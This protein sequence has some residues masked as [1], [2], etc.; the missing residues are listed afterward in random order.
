[1]DK[2]HIFVSVP[3]IGAVTVLTLY[4][5]TRVASEPTDLGQE[6]EAVVEVAKGPHGGRL[7]VDG[8]FSVEVTI[9]ERGVPPMFRVYFLQEGE[10]LDAAQVALKIE[11]QRL[12]GRVDVFEFEKEADYLRGNGVVE[13]PHSF[14]VTVVAERGGR[15]HRW[16][17]P[18]YEGR[19]SFTPEAIESS[20]LVLETTGPATLERTLTIYGRIV[21]NTD[22]QADVIPRYSGVVMATHKALGD[23]VIAGELV[24][25]VQ[26]NESLQSYDVRSP[27]AGTIVH[28]DIRLGEFLPEGRIIYRVTDTST[29]WADMHVY[30]QDFPHLRLN[31]PVAIRGG[32]ELPEVTGT[33]D[34]LSPIGTAATQTML[35]R[36]EL[37]NPDG[38]WR[39]GWF[40]T[41]EVLVERVEVPVAVRASALQTF[42][43]WDVVFVNEGSLFEVRPVELGRR[44][45]AWVEILSGIGAGQKYVAENSF[46]IKADIGK[47]G[48]SHDH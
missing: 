15:T 38:K 20:G 18:S 42:R 46:I 17:Y 3:V 39:P 27:I 16:T 19:V 33:I 10:P 12:G 28:K 26:S 14:D 31:Q 29:V 8:D 24:A 45:A 9:F 48:A 41:A 36:V 23:T 2:K 11:L 43:D 30:R 44:D 37:P 47:S 34:Y 6:A 7:L 1:M 25:V 40:V 22:L 21:P 32:E 4:A 5:A 13:E 35:A